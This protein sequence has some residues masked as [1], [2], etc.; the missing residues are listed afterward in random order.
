MAVT[1]TGANTDPPDALDN[2]GMSLSPIPTGSIPPGDLFL[3]A[4]F[5]TGS[6]CAMLFSSV[7]HL[8]ACH[9]EDAAKQLLKLDLF[10]ISLLIMGSFIGGLHYAFYCQK[11]LRLGYIWVTCTYNRVLNLT[12]F[13]LYL[14][15]FVHILLQTN[16]LLF[17]WLRYSDRGLHYHKL[18]GLFKPYPLP[19][20]QGDLSVQHSIM[21]RGACVTL[22]H[23]RQ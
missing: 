9:S 17:C 13:V 15:N 10:G 20:S 8:Y 11:Q 4:L 6:C 23:Y 14:R 16:F 12:L 18:S 5:Y 7:Y 1:A 3:V 2:E 22:V 19:L 21:V